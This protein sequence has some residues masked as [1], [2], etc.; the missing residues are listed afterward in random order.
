MLNSKFNWTKEKEDKFQWTIWR[1]WFIS[2]KTL[3]NINYQLM[4]HFFQ[5]YILVYFKWK[6]GNL[7]WV[8]LKYLDFLNLVLI[9]IF[10]W[11]AE[12]NVV[13][14][15]IIFQK[16]NENIQNNTRIEKKRKS[17]IRKDL[18]YSEKIEFVVKES[19]EWSLWTEP[20]W[21]HY[22]RNLQSDDNVNSIVANGWEKLARY[23][24][25]CWECVRAVIVECSKTVR[26]FVGDMRHYRKT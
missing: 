9:K 24:K 6:I 14:I 18:N 1:H 15:K 25:A 4:L 22:R 13:K 20:G 26:K 10:P 11:L 12:V 3:F 17:L 2:I 21:S 19:F 7:N 5:Y 23:Y 8:K 16:L